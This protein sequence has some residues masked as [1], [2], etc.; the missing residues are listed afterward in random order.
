M[1]FILKGRIKLY[2]DYNDGIG[3]VENIPFIAYKEG[4]YFGDTDVL[5]GQKE[6]RDG[7]AESENETNVLVI[8]KKK[9]LE[10]L[11]KHE[12]EYERMLHVAHER[13]NNHLE[14]IQQAIE[15][16]EAEGR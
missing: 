8:N 9:L 1:F 6:G 2:Y 13:R 12:D 16:Y 14:M 3:E 5:V 15:K 10:I 7:T 4:S 11:A